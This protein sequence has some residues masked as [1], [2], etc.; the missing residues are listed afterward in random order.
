MRSHNL[1]DQGGLQMFWESP[2]ELHKSPGSRGMIMHQ[3]ATAATHNG[4]PVVA[5]AHLAISATGDHAEIRPSILDLVD[6]VDTSN[7]LRDGSA[8][9][10]VAVHA[11]AP[12]QL[13]TVTPHMCQVAVRAPIL[14]SLQ[15]NGLWS[16][17]LNPIV[18]IPHIL[19][20]G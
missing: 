14:L 2:R 6:L 17:T 8:M 12:H 7:S 1:Y 13:A 3:A 18:S 10:A 11:A 5:L 15:H 9:R 19:Q 16:L 4:S 20:G